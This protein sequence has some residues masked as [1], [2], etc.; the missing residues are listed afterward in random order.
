MI[1]NSLVNIFRHQDNLSFDQFALATL[2]GLM[3]LEREEYLMARELCRVV[4]QLREEEFILD[5]LTYISYPVEVR[6][7]IYTTNSLENLNRQIRRVTKSKVSFDKVE[8]LLD[9]VY[10][11]VK[12]IEESNWQKYGVNTFQYW[13]INTQLI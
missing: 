12:E 4:N 2:E 10:M 9:L 13:P 5:Y 1:H 8:N 11:I 7:Q 6:G 3:L